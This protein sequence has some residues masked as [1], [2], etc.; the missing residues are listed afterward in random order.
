MSH[1]RDTVICCFLSSWKKAKKRPFHA[2]CVGEAA[3]S[4]PIQTVIPQ[5]ILSAD[6]KASWNICYIHEDKVFFCTKTELVP[7]HKGWE[8]IIFK[9]NKCHH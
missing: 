2:L 3:L 1:R 9:H 6:P 7:L 4:F 5:L 8:L